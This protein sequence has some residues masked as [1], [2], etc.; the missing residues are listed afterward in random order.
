M[1]SL[2]DSFFFKAHFKMK[3]NLKPPKLI[4]VA[5]IL[6]LVQ[7]S[8]T[9]QHSNPVD[10]V[11]PTLTENSET[12]T[13]IQSPSFGKSSL[14]GIVISNTNNATLSSVLIYAALKIPMSSGND[15]VLNIQRDSSPHSETDTEGYFYLTNIEPG[16]YQLMLYSP[17][18]AMIL[19]SEDGK[20]IHLE[21]SAN[22]QL[23]LGNLY[24]NWP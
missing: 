9:V 2:E 24:V 3:A 21:I 14:K 20:E 16:E 23:D 17:F 1:T 13:V 11:N 18:G 7:I 4:I 22:Q 6:I 10:M 8:C 12:Q 15:Y 19:L 5:I